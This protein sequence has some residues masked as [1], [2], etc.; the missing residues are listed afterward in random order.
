MDLSLAEHWVGKTGEHLPGPSSH[1]HIPGCQIEIHQTNDFN[2]HIPCFWSIASGFGSNWDSRGLDLVTWLR[3]WRSPG[4][5]KYGKQSF[6]NMLPSP[7][8]TSSY[9]TL[10]SIFGLA[11]IEAWQALHGL[12]LHLL[13]AVRHFDPWKQYLVEP[14]W[15]SQGHWHTCTPGMWLEPFCK[16]KRIQNTNT[17]TLILEQPRP[18]SRHRHTYMV[19]G[20][21]PSILIITPDLI[22]TMVISNDANHWTCITSTIYLMSFLTS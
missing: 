1:I 9:L 19:C 3:H 22:V 16:Y 4:Q 10:I 11:L 18:R 6:S 21:N 17:N 5:P 8:S 12:S 13:A 14:G 7:P 15:T 2:K 20:W